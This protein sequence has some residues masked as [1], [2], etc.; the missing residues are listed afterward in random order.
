[1]FIYLTYFLKFNVKFSRKKFIC[2]DKEN[3]PNQEERK[4]VL[5]VAQKKK[6]CTRL[7]VTIQSIV[8]KDIAEKSNT[9]K[10]TQIYQGDYH[11][12][13]LVHIQ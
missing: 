7:L 4:R 8:G 13:E 2:S 11:L 5:L 6:Y 10:P 12:S 1:M 3:N 9:L